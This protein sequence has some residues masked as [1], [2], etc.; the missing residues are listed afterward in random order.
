MTETTLWPATSKIFVSRLSRKKFVNPCSKV[1]PRVRDRRWFLFL[2]VSVGP[3]S[4]EGLLDSPVS[5]RPWSCVEAE[6]SFF[7]NYYRGQSH[8]KTTSGDLTENHTK[9]HGEKRLLPN[10]RRQPLTQK[11]D[12]GE[13][14]QSHLHLA[15]NLLL[16]D[17]PLSQGTCIWVLHSFCL[18][19]FELCKKEGEKG[20][21]V[22]A[23]GVCEFISE[24][25]VD[26]VSNDSGPSQ[27]LSIMYLVPDY[28]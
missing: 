20:E 15:A 17:C 14:L 13:A 1:F 3:V 11:M 22:G 24:D 2:S 26:I 21:G 18:V 9:F 12:L 19:G 25:R 4:R 27:H 5:L 8:H 7:E 28:P 23:C 10:P 16:R 6:R